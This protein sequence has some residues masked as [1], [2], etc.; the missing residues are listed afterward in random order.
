MHVPSGKIK[1][2]NFLL[3]SECSFKRRET[4]VKNITIVENK[5]LI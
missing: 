1:M 4:A 3:S 5:K 2:G